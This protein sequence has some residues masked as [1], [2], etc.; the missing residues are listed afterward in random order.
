MAT[1][2][3]PATATQPEPQTAPQAAPQ[4]PAHRAYVFA[5]NCTNSHGSFAKGDKARGAFA[6]EL[7]ASYLAAGILVAQPKTEPKDQAA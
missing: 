6:P 1:K 5:K 4:L 7:V 2:F 3:T